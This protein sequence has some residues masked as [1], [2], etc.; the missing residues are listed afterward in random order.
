MLGVA[1]CPP[2]EGLFE[3]KSQRGNLYCEHSNLRVPFRVFLEHASTTPSK[4]RNLEQ[5]DEKNMQQR[6]VKVLPSCTS[7]TS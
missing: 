6:T 5:S 7:W 2:V 4:L 3:G 1:M